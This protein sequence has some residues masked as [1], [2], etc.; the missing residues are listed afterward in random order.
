MSVL[1]RAHRI[2][3]DERYLEAAKG[4]V[5]PFER[6]IDDEGVCAR[7]SAGGVWFEEDT[8]R[9]ARHILNGMI[10]ALWGLDD[11]T[12]VTVAPEARRLY[13]SG[14]ETL[15]EQ[16]ASA[17]EE[18]RSRTGAAAELQREVER[19]RGELSSSREAATVIQSQKASAAY[20]SRSSAQ[21]AGAPEDQLSGRN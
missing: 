6:H 8:R 16:L 20:S 12:R 19:V 3:E 18:G 5:G 21:T 1:V 9:P 11:V 10:F 15:R 4:C 2:T 13:E 14:L 7:W 17:R